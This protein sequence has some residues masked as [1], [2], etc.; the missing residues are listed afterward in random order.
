MYK[1]IKKKWGKKAAKNIPTY[2]AMLVLWFYMGLW[3]GGA[4]HYVAEGIWFWAVIVSGQLLDKQLKG[5]MKFLHI[6]EKAV[7]WHGFQCIRTTLIYGIGVIFFR[8]KSVS[9]ALHY[10]KSGLSPKCLIPGNTIAQAKVY[11]SA[12]YIGTGA[13]AAICVCMGILVVSVLILF[14]AKG[15]SFYKWLGERNLVVRWGFL[16]VILFTIILF[17]AYGPGFDASQFIYGGF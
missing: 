5:I 6:N 7:W 15:K 3:H 4:W 9:Q 12:F 10:I 8:A 17:G 11:L 14:Q 16:Y 2:L 1:Q 13:K